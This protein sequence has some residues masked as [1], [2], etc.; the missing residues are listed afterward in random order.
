MRLVLA[1][2]AAAAALAA[3]GQSG[4]GAAKAGENGATSPAEEKVATEIVDAG[5]VLTL[6][7]ETLSQVAGGQMQ[8]VVMQ[9]PDL[10]QEQ[11]EKIHAAIRTNIDAEIP[12]LK[13]QMSAHLAETFS[14]S[15]LKT[16]QAFVAPPT[17][18]ESIKD[19]VPEV[20][21]KSIAA[22]DAMTSKAVE[23]AVAEVK[24]AAPAAPADD[25]APAEPA[26][27]TDQQ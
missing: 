7:E 4:G 11:L 22:A 19:R 15:E 23:K 1:T 2:M 17:E 18:G 3:C 12:A 8:M 5:G 25:A 16:Y 13:K 6:D 14:E 10:T 21:E 24:G 26:K 20:M 27:P 9:N